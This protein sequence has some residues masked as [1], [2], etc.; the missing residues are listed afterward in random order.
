MRKYIRVED[1][2]YEI[3]DTHNGCSNHFGYK[4][5]KDYTALLDEENI[6]NYRQADTI[7]ELCDAFVYNDKAF[8]N[9]IYENIDSVKTLCSLRKEWTVYATI[10]TDKG[11]IFVAK[12][13]NEGVFE[14][15]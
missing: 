12:M 7:E 6:K 13:N 9:V 4:Y 1:G 5:S 11:L 3:F 14:L 15:I 10:W 2:I 8:K